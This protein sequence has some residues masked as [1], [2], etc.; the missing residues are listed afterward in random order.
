MSKISCRYLTINRYISL[1]LYIKSNYLLFF[2]MGGLELMIDDYKPINIRGNWRMKMKKRI[3]CIV[4]SLL[5]VLCFV[6]T[7]VM[8]QG[9]GTNKSEVTSISLNVKPILGATVGGNNFN[10]TTTYV[11]LDSVAPSGYG[12]GL[13]YR[14]AL[15]YKILDAQYTGNAENDLRSG[16]LQ[17]ISDTTEVFQDG[18]HY[19]V[20]V[21]ICDYGDYSGSLLSFNF[22]DITGT[23][24]GNNASVGQSTKYE[25]D[26]YLSVAAYVDVLGIYDIDMEIT[27]PSLGKAADY[28]PKIINITNDVYDE[29]YGLG[30]TSIYSVTWLKVEKDAYK[31]VEADNWVEMEEDEEYTTGYYY[32]VKFNVL[33]DNSTIY[34][35]LCRT[36]SENL[37]GSL[38]DK[39]FDK[40]VVKDDQYHAELYK[41]FEPLS[42][43][44]SEDVPIKSYDIKDT[45]QDGVV[46]CSEEMNSKDWIWSNTKGACVYKVSNTSAK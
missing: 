10:I 20:D 22:N 28:E 30:I 17:Y 31:D 36:I 14:D 38:N 5:L 26:K 21:V 6:P 41:V 7:T 33:E 3:S 45:N 44:V 32:M 34:D 13:V 9:N 40:I 8:A 15:W 42:E 16:N 25:G 11:S 1:T 4:L 35:W 39:D 23:I 24:N 43:P 29:S 18:Y 27:A 12:D 2:A 37:T 46:D 19:Y